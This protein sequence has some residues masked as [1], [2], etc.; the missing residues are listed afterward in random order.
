MRWLV[1]AFTVV[2]LLELYV[3]LA[4]GQA[5]GFWPTVAWTLFTALTGG[6][7]ARREGL[8]VLTSWRDSLT[9]GTAPSHGVLDGVLILLGGALLITPGVLT[10]VTGLLLLIP[11]TRRVVAAHLRR[12]LDAHLAAAAA[13]TAEPS[14]LDGV[15][16]RSVVETTGTSVGDERDP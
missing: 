14:D 2:P 8:A 1:L 11:P 10:D 13:M 15:R 5:V 7:L 12:R 9:G 4:V 3:L 16:V 6:A